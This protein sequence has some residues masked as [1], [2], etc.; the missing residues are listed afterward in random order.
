MDVF[1]IRHKLGGVSP[2]LPDEQPIYSQTKFR[3]I[4][5]SSAISRG[6]WT[7]FTCMGGVMLRITDRRVIL[8]GRVFP[9][10]A[11]ETDLW[12]HG[13]GAEVSCDV[14]QTVS[15]AK[16]H[17]GECVEIHGRNPRRRQT[18]F[19]S[20]DLIARIYCDDPAEIER[21]LL[22]TMAGNPAGQSIQRT[23]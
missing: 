4:T 7:S 14:I 8:S 12:F 15:L 17:Y 16:G 6:L 22:Q 10:Y 20:P 9:F 1:Y 19:T 23:Q 11:Q 5:L 3:A 2:L 13:G 18:W 21:I